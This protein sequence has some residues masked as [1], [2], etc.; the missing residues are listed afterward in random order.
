MREIYQTVLLP[1][2]VLLLLAGC[3]AVGPDYAPP[4]SP[5]PTKFG[6]PTFGLGVGAVEVEW[7]RTFDDPV[8]TALI[9]QAL[10]ANHDIGIAAMRLEEAKAMPLSA[11]IRRWA[12]VG[13]SV[14]RRN[15]IVMGPAA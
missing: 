9:Q 15:A 2:S 8:L 5:L 10:A 4:S 14:P 7:W 1:L 12:A 11:S 13:K 6:E 3:S